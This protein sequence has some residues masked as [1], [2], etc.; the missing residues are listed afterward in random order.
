MR[1][2][3]EQKY[4]NSLNFWIIAYG[5]MTDASAWTLVYANDATGK[6]TYGSLSTLINAKKQGQD[7][8]VAQDNAYT[9]CDDVQ[10][11]PD[12]LVVLYSNTQGISLNPYSS[13]SGF[14]FQ[15]DAYHWFFV[16]NTKGQRDMSRWSVGEHIDRGHAHDAIPIKWY[17]N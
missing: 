16:V 14:G 17:V 10:I 12:N 1:Q 13:G 7:V 9:K 4:Y 5:I 2:E 8:K 15:D 3:H 11:S 6:A